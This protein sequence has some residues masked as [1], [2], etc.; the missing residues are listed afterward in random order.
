MYVAGFERLWRP[1]GDWS[2]LTT[3]WTPSAPSMPSKSPG[4]VR[5]ST[6]RFQRALYRISLISVLLPE[7]EAPVT[8]ISLPSGNLTST[9][10]RLFSLAPRTVSVLPSPWR[11]R[12]GV[13]MLRLPERNWPVGDAL[14]LRI[15]SS[16]PSTTTSPP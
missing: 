15:S 10:L 6:S 5:V 9:D 13:S 11:R 1:I 4:N 8:A 14:H 3:L 2:M 12:D 7:P 16:V